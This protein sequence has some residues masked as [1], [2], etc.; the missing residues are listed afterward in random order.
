MQHFLKAALRPARARIIPSEPLEQFLVAVD[1]AIAA[2]HAGFAQGTP[3]AAC[4]CAQ[5]EESVSESFVFFAIRPP[6]WSEH[7]R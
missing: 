5:K 3:G 1:H 2:L 4:S 6:G 7:G